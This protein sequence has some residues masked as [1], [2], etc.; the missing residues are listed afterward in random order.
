MSTDDQ[1]REA[2]QRIGPGDD[3]RTEAMEE[4]R[5][6]A[7]RK[8]RQRKVALGTCG[9]LIAGLIA[10]AA[11]AFQ[12]SGGR[13]QVAQVTPGATRDTT[14]VPPVTTH[15]TRPDPRSLPQQ[16][17]AKPPITAKNT[18]ATTALAGLVQ[19]YLPAG[20]K[21]TDTLDQ[22]SQETNGH[23]ISA[24]FVGPNSGQYYV[25]TQGVAP[26]D[27][28]A[29]GLLGA[30]SPLSGLPAGLTGVVQID[31]M[32]TT[33]A[34]LRPGAP[35]T[36]LDIRVTNATGLTSAQLANTAVEVSGMAPLASR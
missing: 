23:S 3:D 27:M 20:Y 34:I 18:A 25:V 24:T 15:G 33:V 5:R 8:T 13:R 10:G 19:K 2:L 9:L 6:R 21:L 4:V 1:I 16:S 36:F 28:K 26:D 11:I 35:A 17:Q 32:L 14:P 30:S 7:S 12:G 29:E 31:Q 22:K